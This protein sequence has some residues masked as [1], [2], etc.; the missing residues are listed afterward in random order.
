MD[1]TEDGKNCEILRDA[2]EQQLICDGFIEHSG[3]LL[4]KD[5]IDAYIDERVECAWFACLQGY[6]LAK[7]Q[8]VPEGFVLLEQKEFNQMSEFEELYRRA[9]FNSKKSIHEVNW[10]HVSGLGVS[11]TKAKAMCKRFNIDSE[12]TFR[13]TQGPTN[14]S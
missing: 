6:R 5:S 14:E 3:Y 2:F 1:I 12:A 4:E 7:T 13:K 11:S 10:S 9:I 8:T